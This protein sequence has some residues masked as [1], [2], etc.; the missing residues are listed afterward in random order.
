MD[1]SSWLRNPFALKELFDIFLSFVSPLKKPTGEGSTKK[2]GDDENVS[3]NAF[4]K[5]DEA[6]FGALMLA[7]YDFSI[8]I[9]NLLCQ[10]LA[11]LEPH[12]ADD[13]RY[14]VV[15]MRLQQYRE[16]KR[17]SAKWIR[18]GVSAK[19][20]GK[21]EFFT[22]FSWEDLDVRYTS[23][24]TRVR[25]LIYL[26]A[27]V[28]QHREDGARDIL[29]DARI[30]KAKSLSEEAKEVA[31]KAMGFLQKRWRDINAAMAADILG[32]L[33]F[34][35]ILEYGR[36]NNLS[37]DEV[38]KLVESRSRVV[39]EA[40]LCELKKTRGGGLSATDFIMIGAAAAMVIIAV[41]VVLVKS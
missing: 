40:R 4:T 7:L 27:L 33:N 11:I 26:A 23:L 8:P 24:D 14:A 19:G 25:Y 34:E 17:K 12:Q 37:D 20:P 38:W 13:L 41:A 18:T 30:I 36:R 39:A 9:H 22:E 15:K 3:A 6:E 21:D 2:E 28:Y 1:F 32:T 31:D 5:E 35:G 10:L 16:E 29:I